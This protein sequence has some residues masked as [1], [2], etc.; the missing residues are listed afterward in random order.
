[1]HNVSPPI[2][3][4]LHLSGSKWSTDQINAKICC[5]YI[6]TKI[7]QQTAVMPQQILQAYKRHD[8]FYFFCGTRQSTRWL[9]TG[10]VWPT[11]RTLCTAAEY[12]SQSVLIS[13]HHLRSS[14]T[15]NWQTENGR[16]EAQADTSHTRK[17]VSRSRKTNKSEWTT[18]P[19]LILICWHLGQFV[20]IRFPVQLW[21]WHVITQ[22]IN[23]C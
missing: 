6:Y 17:H 19:A 10:R 15:S 18:N 9:L 11:G 23:S 20:C 2:I 4:F 5:S 14:G 13:C 22:K 12:C 16:R 7:E 8:F 21:L 1:V 3:S